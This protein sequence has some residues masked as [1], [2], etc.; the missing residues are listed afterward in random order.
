MSFCPDCGQRC[1]CIRR[2][3]THYTTGVM[4]PCSKCGHEMIDKDRVFLH[5]IATI[6]L[7]SLLLGIQLPVESMWLNALMVIGLPFLYFQLLMPMRH[8]KEPSMRQ[9]VRILHD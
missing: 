9:P 2:L 4:L 5:I 3:L 8:D 6:G 7:F 1:C